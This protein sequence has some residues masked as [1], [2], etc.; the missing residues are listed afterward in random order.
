MNNPTIDQALLHMVEWMESVRKAAERPSAIDVD[1]HKPA[2]WPDL[3]H[4]RGMAERKQAKRD[5]R[6]S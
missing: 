4:F 3:V 6:S 5:A 2:G 1:A